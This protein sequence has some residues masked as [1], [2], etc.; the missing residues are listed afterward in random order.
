MQG[1]AKA[2]F[3]R[4]RASLKSS[5]NDL[6]GAE[7]D[8]VEARKLDPEN[9]NIKLQYANLLW[10]EGRKDES[11]QIYGEVLG[12]DPANRYALEAMGYLYREENNPKMAA[13]YFNRLAKDYPDDYVP[14][15]ALGDCSRK[16]RSSSAPM[17]IIRR[18][19][20]LRLRIR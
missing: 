4:V 12:K 15:L 3:L 5:D 14:Y 11:R 9:A 7:A 20:S 1:T 16:P 10:K 18:L 2:E 8:L 13:E 19:T 17:R 6:K